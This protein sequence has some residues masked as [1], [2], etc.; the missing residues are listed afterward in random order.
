M[1]FPEETE[2]TDDTTREQAKHTKECFSNSLAVAKENGA[3]SQKEARQWA[4]T[5]LARGT[6]SCQCYY[7]DDGG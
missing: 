4:A 2:L 6:V 1:R 7:D 3:A 5:Y